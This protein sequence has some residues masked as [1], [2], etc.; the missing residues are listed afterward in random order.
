VGAPCW[1]ELFSS[2]TAAARAFYGQLFGWTSGA[3]GPEY[4]GYVNFFAQ[5]AP[6]A[7]CMANDGQ[8]GVPDAWSIYLAVDDARAT[9]DRA[10]ANGGQVIVE[11]MEVPQLGTMAVI[12]D[13][14]GAA[15]GIWQPALHT[16]FQ[17]LGEPGAPSWFELHT[18]EYDKSVAFYRE[19]FGWQTHALGDTPDFRYTTLGEG[20]DQLA[21]IMDAS[22]FLLEGVPANW[23][24]YFGVDNTDAALDQIVELGGIVVLPAEDTPYGRL[25][26]AAD[27]TGAVFKL[28]AG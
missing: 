8:T 17:V 6:V 7:G 13:A 10:L 23:S 1:I 26:A 18:R 20:D 11:P 2:D 5:G 14:G 27:P 25:A 19:V 9:T 28:V 12:T 15:I 24:V 22:G 21:G 3:A 4:G 16:G